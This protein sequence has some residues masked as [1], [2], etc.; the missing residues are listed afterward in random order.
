V[1]D[2]EDMVLLINYLFKSAT[3]PDP[4]WAGDVNCNQDVDI[5]DIIFLIN[6]V[7]KSG[8]EPCAG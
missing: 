6:Y 5:S 8:P 1:V 4:V 3:A 2:V 7:L